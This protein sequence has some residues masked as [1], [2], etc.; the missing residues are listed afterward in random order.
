VIPILRRLWA[1]LE[2]V[3]LFF[4]GIRNTLEKGADRVNRQLDGREMDRKR[5]KVISDGFNRCVVGTLVLDH[6][7]EN[8]LIREARF[9]TSAASSLRRTE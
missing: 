7:L 3:I 6:R 8:S 2:V 9:R 4:H 1:R 5:R